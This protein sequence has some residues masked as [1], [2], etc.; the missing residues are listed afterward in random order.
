MLF[1]VN[2]A[3][4]EELNTERKPVKRCF[5]KHAELKTRTKSNV[6]VRYDFP[7]TSQLCNS[8]LQIHHICTMCNVTIFNL[9]V[10]NLPCRSKLQQTKRSTERIIGADLS[11]IQDFQD[12]IQGQERGS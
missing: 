2:E 1:R 3:T 9:V 10:Y 8:L 7:S 11:S 5:S 6:K 4:W 12:S